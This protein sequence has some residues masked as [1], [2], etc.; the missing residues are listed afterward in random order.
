MISFSVQ[1][2]V[3]DSLLSLQKGFPREFRRGLTT[4]GV[5]FRARIRRALREGRTPSGAVPALS[6]LTLELRRARN[7]RVRGHG[8]ILANALRYTITGR[9]SDMTLRVGFTASRSAAEA[10]Q[11]FQSSE[12]KTFSQEQRKWLRLTLIHARMEGNS[13]LFNA[14]RNALHEGYRKPERAFIE[15]FA[16]PMSQDAVRIVRGRIQSIIQRAKRR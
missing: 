5:T 3:S 4:L 2:D 15:P 8:G 6:R 9:G 10:A 16:V 12:Q 14:A 7:S 1:E 13:A 11:E